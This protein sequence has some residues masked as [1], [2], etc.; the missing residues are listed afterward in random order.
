MLGFNSLATSIDMDPAATDELLARAIG[1]GV[2]PA[3]LLAWMRRQSRG[4]VAP[5]LGTAMRDAAARESLAARRLDVALAVL[6]AAGVPTLVLK[7]AAIS[8]LCYPEPW[9]RPR[10]D[11]DVLVPGDAFDGARA[12]LRDA[13]YQAAPQNPAPEIVGQAHLH[14]PIDDG[15]FHAI[16]LHARPLVPAAFCDLPAFETLAAAAVPLPAIGPGARGPS[17]PHALLLGC[18]HRVAHHTPTEDPTWL[19]DLHLLAERLDD[20]QWADFADLAVRSRVAEVCAAEL[21]RGISTYQTP[22]PAGVLTRLASVRGEESA[23]YLVA[24][25]P[26]YSH[27]LQFRYRSGVLARAGM[28]AHHL[29]PPRAYME[30]RFGAGPSYKLPWLYARRAVMGFGRWAHEFA[31]RRRQ[32]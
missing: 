2:R 28:V 17:A 29:L 13:G 1:E 6:R 22:V 11:D 19:V 18:A 16:D 10:N 30:A 26:L 9:L 3:L 24:L 7:G 4:A 21:R 14:L 27:W 31:Q 20:R 32:A 8:Q 12:A 25:G 15:H 5:V 23:A